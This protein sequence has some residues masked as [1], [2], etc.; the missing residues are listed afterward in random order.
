MTILATTE[1]VQARPAGDP[2]RRWARVILNPASGA[3]GGLAQLP[4][5][6]AALEGIGMQTVISF[7]GAGAAPDAVAAEAV[8]ERY[9]M[10]VAVG[11]DGTVSSV[12]RGMLQSNVPLGIIP[13]GTYNNIARSLD[14]PFALDG[15]LAVLTGGHVRQID[16]AMANGKMFMEVAGVGIDARIFPMAEEIKSGSWHRIAAA[17]RTLRYFRPRKLRIELADG[18]R[19]IT[20]PLMALVSNLPYFGVGFAIAP[21]ARA[22]SGDLTLSLFQN[23]TKL[24]LLQYF[25][26]IAYG[27][28]VQEP[29]VQT[30]TSPR[31]RI[32]T[33]ARPP[34]RVQTD[35]QVVGMT[36]LVCEVQ[37]GA[38]SVVAPAPG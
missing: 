25:A 37:P 17:L 21:G 36:P 8:R 28:I 16:A 6:V 11:G 19:I 34:I 38:L 35:G 31:I 27:R 22:D 9:D 20:R 29:R 32:A 23:F 1:P 15:A 24:E 2:A 26:G 4:A 14:I 13:L 30:Y 12:A 18:Q 33:T 5:I 7:V 10:V 3:Q